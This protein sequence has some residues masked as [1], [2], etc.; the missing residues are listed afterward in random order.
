MTTRNDRFKYRAYYKHDKENIKLKIEYG[1]AYSMEII[2][3]IMTGYSFIHKAKVLMPPI[4][5]KS[6]E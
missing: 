6:G 2:G 1:L 4:Q 3:L 5:N